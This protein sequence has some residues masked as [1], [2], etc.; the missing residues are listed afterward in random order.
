MGFLWGRPQGADLWAVCGPYP[1]PGRLARPSVPDD[2]RLAD[3]RAK[4][5]EVPE[6]G[7]ERQAS[8]RAGRADQVVRDG[9]GRQ[10]HGVRGENAGGKMSERAAGDVGEHLLDDR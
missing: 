10:P 7:T 8:Q 3:S 9:R 1:R 5:E 6:R 2:Q 4:T